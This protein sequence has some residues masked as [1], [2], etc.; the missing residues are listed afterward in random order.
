MESKRRIFELGTGSGSTTIASKGSQS[1]IVKSDGGSSTIEVLP[2]NDINL[3]CAGSGL[4]KTAGGGVHFG[5]LPTSDPSIAGRLY[6][7][8]SGFVKISL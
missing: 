3:Y 4:V 1:I 2:S 7:D 8:S 6:R 5:T